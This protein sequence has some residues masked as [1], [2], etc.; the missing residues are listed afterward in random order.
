[1]G[2]P[3]AQD[4]R[5]HWA[6]QEAAAA[7]H[8]APM[9]MN[10]PPQVHAAHPRGRDRRG[11]SRRRPLTTAVLTLG[12]AAAVG[13]WMFRE[14]LREF[15]RNRT[16]G[17]VTVQIP[18]LPDQPTEPALPEPSATSAPQKA[19]DATGK[20][21][22][23]ESGSK[24]DGSL[25]ASLSQDPDF[26]HGTE[27]AVPDAA[28]RPGNAPNGLLEVPSRPVEAGIKSS[29]AS[30]GNRTAKIS[31]PGDPTD[32]VKTPPKL[33]GVPENAMPA[34][35]ALQKFLAASGLEE[36]MRYTLAPESMRNYMERY[37]AANSA[38]P[39][40]VDTIAFVR[41]DPKPQIG[42]GAHA[43]FGLESRQWQFP[44]P[45]MLEESKDGFR[46]DWLS[47]VEFKDRLLERFFHEYTQGP[48]L[49][50]VGLTRT[51]YFEDGVPNADQKDAFTVTSAPTNPFS[52]TIFVDKKSALGQ[53]LKDKIPWGTQ[54]WAIAEL[55]WLK[56]GD[57]KWVQ[58][59]AVPQLNWYSVPTTSAADS[60]KAPSSSSSGG[61]T[62]VQRAVP[63]GR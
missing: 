56:L 15:I 25:T 8:A 1:M 57:Q 39:V 41:L 22:P 23:D 49:F 7:M 59:A 32:L 43:V 37:Y 40:H 36:R 38:G 16:G 3:P 31:E 60:S 11:P 48:A 63:I 53:E 54:V 6:S 28:V 47:F 14:P 29:E 18:H 35:E 50:H 62:E 55:E 10:L 9:D 30:S 34:A 20:F 46:V 5:T 12:V 61:P 21:N 45:V 51:H 44:V 27:K 52:A 58:L 19:E 4:P 33:D 17:G 24:S 2:A 42:S 13:A 26:L